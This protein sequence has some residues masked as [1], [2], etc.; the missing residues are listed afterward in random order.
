MARMMP[1]KRRYRSIMILFRPIKFWPK[2]PRNKIAL[3]P[4]SGAQKSRACGRAT[5]IASSTSPRPLCV[6]VSSMQPAKRSRACR[7]RIAKARLTMSLPDG[8]RARRAMKQARSAISPQLW[9]RN[10]AT[11]PIN[12]TSPRFGSNRPIRRKTR[13]RGQH[14]STW[15]KALRFAPVPFALC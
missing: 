5:L 15:S 7:R 9:Q 1:R 6:S 14:W 3:K 13:R 4:W 2:Q 12:T 11:K 10:R 8:W